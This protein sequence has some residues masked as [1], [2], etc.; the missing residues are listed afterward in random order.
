MKW[1][2]IWIEPISILP[3]SVYHLWITHTTWQNEMSCKLMCYCLRRE[4]CSVYMW[5]FSNTVFKGLIYF[6][7][8]GVWACECSA[9]K[10]QRDWIPWNCRQRSLE[11]RN[12]LNLG[13]LQKQFSPLTA[14]PFSRPWILLI[15]SSISV[16]QIYKCGTSHRKGWRHSCQTQVWVTH[17]RQRETEGKNL[18]LASMKS[19]HFQ[20]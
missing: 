5:S 13:S 4:W 17:G 9:Y 19:E 11:A 16:D 20:M 1:H 6:K 15:F 14:E 18:G 2:S 8:V 12:G 3:Y 7:D 10:G